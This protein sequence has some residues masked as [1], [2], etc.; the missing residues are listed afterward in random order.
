MLAKGKPPTADDGSGAQGSFLG[1]R[2]TTG[3][4]SRP[5]PRKK[6]AEFSTEVRSF[7]REG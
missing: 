5:V 2:K 7:R 3:R 1:D 4:D 6:E